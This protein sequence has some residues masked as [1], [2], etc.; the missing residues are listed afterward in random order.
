MTQL[1]LLF[2]LQIFTS[3]TSADNHDYPG[4]SLEVTNHGNVVYSVILN[5]GSEMQPLQVYLSTFS[6][7]TYFELFQTCQRGFNSELSKSYS[8]TNITM[9]S[10]YIKQNISGTVAVDIISVSEM[11]EGLHKQNL[12]ASNSC[13]LDQGPL[14][15]ALG[16]G[17][18]QGNS[19]GKYSLLQ[20]YFSQGL[21]Y[22]E[23]FSLYLD[24]IETNQTSKNSKLIIGGWNLD[25][26]AKDPNKGFTYH[27]VP[28]QN[29]H[30]S[31]ML[32]NIYFV[33]AGYFV[34]SPATIDIV[35][36]G[37]LIP[38]PLIGQIYRIV[39]ST[40]TCFVAKYSLM[41]DCSIKN[42]ITDITFTI[43]NSNYTISKDKFVIENSG[44]CSVLI[45]ESPT[46]SW[47]LGQVF[48]KNFYTIWNFGNNSIGF[49][50][51]K[52]HKKNHSSKSSVISRN[53]I[54]IIIVIISAL[55]IGTAIGVIF[56]IRKKSKARR[57]S[58]T[59]RDSFMTTEE[60][61][62]RM[63]N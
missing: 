38:Q 63:L 44:A 11:P 60:E 58:L 62:S 45:S 36:P 15:G 17:Y 30:W 41:C 12:L 59:S 13:S 26:Y 6:S 14:V 32:K 40:K 7:V 25:D 16:L 43:D 55:I 35:Y 18:S 29:A 10:D 27:I 9:T 47:L 57:E 22:N 39:N 51:L 21:I 56:I 31:L 52:E 37:I 46:P 42:D 24:N 5:V 50:E 19:Q 34:D 23:A 20:Q 33:G 49:A 28:K 53:W 3:L 54:I 48:V 4:F 2:L 61:N 1:L 8:T